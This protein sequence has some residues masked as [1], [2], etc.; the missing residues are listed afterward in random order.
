MPFLNVDEIKARKI[1]YKGEARLAVV[2]DLVN[3]LYGISRGIT[4]DS[5]Y[6]DS[7][8]MEDL[9]KHKLTLTEE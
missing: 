9:L 2:K 1:W 3:P 8:F 4:V 6:T 5:F 7:N